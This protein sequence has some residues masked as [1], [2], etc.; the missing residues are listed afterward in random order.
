MRCSKSDICIRS[1]VLYFI[2]IYKLQEHDGESRNRII[3]FY[4]ISESKLHHRILRDC[5]QQ[6]KT[7]SIPFK[8]CYADF[9]LLRISNQGL[10]E[11]SSISSAWGIVGRWAYFSSGFSRHMSIYMCFLQ[12]RL[13]PFLQKENLSWQKRRVFPFISISSTDLQHWE[14]LE[15][16][17]WPA[18]WLPWNNE[19]A[20]NN[21]SPIQSIAVGSCKSHSGSVSFFHILSCSCSP[22]VMPPHILVFII[23]EEIQHISDF[24]PLAGGILCKDRN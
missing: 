19:E 8:I 10:T 7:V 2:I 17:S 4:H 14:G 13:M 20:E 23:S 3:F 5:Y 1:G 16:G 11:Q 12:G 15:I 22:G 6:Q 21:P 9:L 18:Q 24:S